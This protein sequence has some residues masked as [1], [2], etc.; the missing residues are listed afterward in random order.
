MNKHGTEMLASGGRQ[1]KKAI[2]AILIFAVILFLANLAY[3]AFAPG[4]S[5]QAQMPEEVLEKAKIGLSSAK[6]VI[7]SDL[8]KWGFNSPEEADQIY[9]GE[10]FEIFYIGDKAFTTNQ[11]A[12]LL[13]ARDESRYPAW[14]FTIAF[15]G[16]QKMV[17]FIYKVETGEYFREGYHEI[18]QYYSIARKAFAE[19]AGDA[20]KP[21]LMQFGPQFFFVMIHNM[22]ELVLPIPYDDVSARIVASGSGFVSASQVIAAIRANSY[23]T[24]TGERIMKNEYVDVWKTNP[25]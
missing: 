9:L 5:I 21:I 6:V 15:S 19:K 10:W 23:L 14:E 20:E 17:F 12:S 18:G 16:Q 25:E 22:E 24:Q 2:S 11:T 13:S 1:T 3:Q 8:E 7:K 4:I